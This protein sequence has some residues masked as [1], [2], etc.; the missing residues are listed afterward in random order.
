MVLIRVRI[1]GWDG[2][3]ED[4]LCLNKGTRYLWH[5][6]FQSAPVLGKYRIWMS[7]KPISWSLDR[8]RTV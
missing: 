5:M 7:M 6:A 1:D 2:H 8:M 4:I 3:T